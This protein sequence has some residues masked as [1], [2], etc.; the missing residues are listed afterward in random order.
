MIRRLLLPR[1]AH[2]DDDVRLLAVSDETDRALDSAANRVALGRIDGIVGAG[3]L[4]P[5][6]LGFLADA[7]HAP[8]IY[9]RGNHDR[10]ENWDDR[11]PHLPRP[12][13]RD[14]DE[15]RGLRVAGL[16][17]PGRAGGQAIHDEGAAW[18][19]AIG[20]WLRLRGK[21]PHVVLSHVPPRGVG[22]VPEDHYHR[23]FAAYRWL[24]R[25]LAPRL[26]IHGHTALSAVSGWRQDWGG[27]TF[28]NA[29]GAVLVE[30][31]ARIS[32]E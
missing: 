5:D 12:L 13:G 30:F 31:A 32:D 2:L 15:L 14:T 20:L 22:D 4:A 29:T 11:R 21:R 18:R 16:S 27:T 8:L 7:F 23:G 6:Y 1:P 19:Q 17:W 10:G 3:D 9:V 24:W 25:R 28:V 26:W